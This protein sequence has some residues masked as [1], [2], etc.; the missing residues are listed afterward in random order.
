MM[1]KSLLQEFFEEVYF[2]HTSDKSLLLID[3]WSTYNDMESIEY[4]RPLQKKLKIMKIPPKTTGIIQPLDVYFF[5]MWKDFVRKFSD[6]VL[7]E[8]LPVL[9]YQRDNILK[10]QS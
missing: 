8:N 3:S 1:T 5:R 2:P 6:R 10:L 4:V 7:L 9:L